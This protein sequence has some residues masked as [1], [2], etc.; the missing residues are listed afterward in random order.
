M[1]LM[2]DAGILRP[3]GG[4]EA[5][6]I[7]RM[8]RL[9]SGALV[10]AAVLFASSVRAQAPSPAQAG[11]PVTR[12]ADPGVFT[13]PVL[14]RAE[15][16][17][18]RLEVKPGGTRRA[19][20]HDDVQFHLFIPVS[21]S[22]RLTRN[23]EAIDSVVGQVYFLDKGTPHTF[24]NAGTTSA[25][26]VEVFVKPREL[27]PVAGAQP[28]SLAAPRTSEVDP[29]VFNT[30]PILDRAE[31]RAG[32]VEVRPGSTRRLHQHNEVQFHLFIPI[33]GSVRMTM[34]GE[35]I[36]SAVGQVYFIGKGAPHTFTNAGT[37]NATAV[38]VFVKPR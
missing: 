6:R 25:S 26:A 37:S 12:E 19:H 7:G 38:E 13:T 24:T 4:R 18:S 8:T 5:G 33:A 3:A 29:G 1:L 15:V 32:R 10:A 35:T 34:N 23:G 31:M 16:R 14:D 9:A 28:P 27:A 22:I 36:D 30:S 20:Q 11:A 21:G 17:A 2:A